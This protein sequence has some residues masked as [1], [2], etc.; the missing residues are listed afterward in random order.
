MRLLL[1]LF[2]LVQLHSL[3]LLGEKPVSALRT[4]SPRASVQAGGCAEPTTGHSAARAGVL[5]R[6]GVLLQHRTCCC[7]LCNSLTGKWSYL[8]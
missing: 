4:S 8:L 3:I 2:L 1:L 6:H 7:C 5:S